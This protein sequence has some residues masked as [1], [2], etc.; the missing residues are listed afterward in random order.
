MKLTSFLLVWQSLLAIRESP[1]TPPPPPPR[2][3]QTCSLCV[4]VSSTELP[5]VPLGWRRHSYVLSRLWTEV[6][7]AIFASSPKGSAFPTLSASF[8]ILN[9]HMVVTELQP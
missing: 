8:C 6:M 7:R 4:T 5:G 2:L 9:L 3:I 1:F